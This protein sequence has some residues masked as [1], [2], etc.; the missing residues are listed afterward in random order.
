MYQVK[1][2]YQLGLNGHHI[3][4]TQLTLLDMILCLKWKRE[5]YMLV[6]LPIYDLQKISNNQELG[7][8]LLLT[9]FCTFFSLRVNNIKLTCYLL[10]NKL[11]IN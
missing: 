1:L 11:I 7:L 2:M 10:L 9:A 4:G 3:E 6:S 8:R 5:T